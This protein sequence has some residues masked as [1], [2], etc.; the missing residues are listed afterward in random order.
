MGRKGQIAWNKGLTKETDERVRKYAKTNSESQKGNKNR[1]IDGIKSYRKLVKQWG[2]D[3]KCKQCGSIKEKL[4]VHHKDKDHHN[5]TPEN[6]EILCYSCHGKHHNYG[7]NL[8]VHLL[9]FASGFKDKVLSGLK[10]QTLRKPKKIPIKVGDELL[11]FGWEGVPYRSK[12]GWRRRAIVTE[13]FLVKMGINKLGNYFLYFERR[14]GYFYDYPHHIGDKV[15]EDLA[16]RDGF[17]DGENYL[18]L[19]QGRLRGDLPCLNP[20]WIKISEMKPRL[21]RD[22]KSA[23]QNMFEWIDNYYGLEEAKSFQ[24]IRFKEVK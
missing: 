15:V 24:V 2:W 20:K 21:V 3:W 18:N 13:T 14:D 1:F 23:A 9:A 4:S 7:K 22:T 10:L 5:N 12:W 16:K 6:L 8:K 19:K 11:L 17:E